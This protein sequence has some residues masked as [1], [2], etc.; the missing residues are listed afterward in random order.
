[1]HRE[2]AF[3]PRGGDVPY[4]ATLATLFRVLSDKIPRLIVVDDA[5]GI[6]VKFADALRIGKCLKINGFELDMVIAWRCRLFFIDGKF[7]GL[8]G[9]I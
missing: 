8:S 1:M 4:Y 7:I 5:A 6:T 2:T 3:E 9:Q